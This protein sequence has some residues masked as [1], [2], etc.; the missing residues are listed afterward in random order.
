MEFATET[1]MKHDCDA[2]QTSL[3]VLSDLVES[4]GR[5]DFADVLLRICNSAFGVDTCAVFRLAN[6]KL[7]EIASAS[8][9][10][11]EDLNSKFL[12]AYDVKR[13]LSQVGSINAKV[14]VQSIGLAGQPS[15]PQRVFISAQRGH[16]RFCIGMLRSA[17]RGPMPVDEMRLLRSLAGIILALCARHIE[18]VSDLVNPTPLL[19]SLATIQECL[20]NQT[21]LS[22]REVEVCARILFGMSSYGIATDLGIGKESVMTYRKRAYQRMGI[23]TQRELLMWY[24]ARRAPS[25]ISSDPLLAAF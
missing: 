22:K 4:I 24:L 19:N 15:R 5:P 16:D 21:D 25:E 17:A 8:L 7:A 3:S 2:D 6:Y 12:G 18:L 23:A 10:G 9:T 11:A 14:D 1:T 20:A 13:Q